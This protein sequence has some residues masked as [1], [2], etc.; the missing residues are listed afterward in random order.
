MANPGRVLSDLLRTFNQNLTGEGKVDVLRASCEGVRSGRL[1]RGRATLVPSLES[2]GQQLHAHFA[3]LGEL[4][5]E[6]GLPVFALE[7]GLGCDEV[8][9]LRQG[10][11]N[12]L[13]TLLR[14][15]HR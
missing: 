4:K 10:L 3:H 12:S 15:V 2:L 6:A 9:A 13:R 7:H 5:R 1:P 8:E 14:R 11:E